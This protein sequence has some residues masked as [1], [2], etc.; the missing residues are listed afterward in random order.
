MFSYS[1]FLFVVFL[2]VF[3]FVVACFCLFVCFFNVFYV[4]IGILCKVWSTTDS[5]AIL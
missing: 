3:V 4:Q 1:W 2:F 5:N